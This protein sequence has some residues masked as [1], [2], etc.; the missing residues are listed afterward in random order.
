MNLTPV[1]EG[2]SPLTL[3]ADTERVSLYAE[4]GSCSL[5]AYRPGKTIMVPPGRYRLFAYQFLR[6][7][8]QGDLWQLIAG[9]TK[10]SPVVTVDGSGDAVLKF[11]EPYV[12][13]VD[14]PEYYLQEVR[15]RSGKQVQLSF[16]VEGAGRELLTDLQR[17]SGIS[18][19]IKL[20]RAD[21]NRPKEPTYMIWKTDG[22]MAARGSFEYG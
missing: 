3:A 18:S 20:S 11:G 15:N 13:V 2:L 9:G 12:P 1:S 16:N 14:V 8:L 17:I 21:R 4:D 19:R 10:E 7:D 6:R 5:M 22:E